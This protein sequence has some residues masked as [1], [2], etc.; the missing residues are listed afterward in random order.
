MSHKRKA[1]DTLHK[2]STELQRKAQFRNTYLNEFLN[3]AISSVRDF[4]T[5]LCEE[6]DCLCTKES[7]TESS[8]LKVVV[9]RI[10]K[11][12]FEKQIRQI[13]MKVSLE[14]EDKILYCKTIDM[15][16]NTNTSTDEK[17][18]A[19][20]DPNTIQL[21]TKGSKTPF[22]IS[23]QLLHDEII[24]DTMEGTDSLLCHPH[25]LRRGLTLLFQID[26]TIEQKDTTTTTTTQR[27][28]GVWNVTDDDKDERTVWIELHNADNESLLFGV[29]ECS[30]QWEWE[31]EWEH[32]EHNLSLS[33]AD[34]RRLLSTYEKEITATP[35]VHSHLRQKRLIMSSI[36]LNASRHSLE[37][38]SPFYIDELE[39]QRHALTDVDV[40]VDVDINVDIDEE[41]KEKKYMQSQSQTSVHL[42]NQ[43]NYYCLW[44]FC[45][46]QFQYSFVL[47]CAICYKL[48][49]VFI[50]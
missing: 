8:L 22:E 38:Q 48:F 49:C 12:K 39:R 35:S 28:V 15:E 7:E 50:F 25:L 27:S 13:Q 30:V 26:V 23:V 36:Q 31:W 46:P 16:M 40:N 21:Q 4:A 41:Q 20:N 11:S 18:D 5:V 3:A 42:E 10:L 24:V 47:C 44:Q 29:L 33:N 34:I 37:K 32:S 17:L 43:H 45:H 2:N 14:L 1:E 19:I 6:K 9:N